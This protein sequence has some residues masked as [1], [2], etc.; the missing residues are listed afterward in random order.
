MKNADIELLAGSAGFAHILGSAP[1][2]RLLEQI[3][4]G[5]YAVEQLVELTGLSVANTSQHL[6]Q[7]RR[8]GFV[9]A[10]RDGKRVLY[11]L[12]SGPVMQLLDALELYAQHQRSELQALGRGDHVEAITGDELLERMQEASITVLDVRPA[13]EFAAG[14]LPGAINIPFDDL[15]RRLGELPANA[16][17]A[18]Y[19]RGPYC[20]LSV[21]AVAA[22]RL[23]GLPARRLGS[24]YDDWQAAGLP[25]VKAA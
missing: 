1:R 24:G 12:G 25:V 7:L 16:E 11:R 14:H 15:Q 3:A 4:H 19:C 5:E 21:Q 23:H 10:R 6:Q 22:L 8:A 18:A 9:Q 20:V 2:L 17:I 13:Q